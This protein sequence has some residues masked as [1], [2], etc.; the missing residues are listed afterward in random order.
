V[1]TSSNHVRIGKTDYP[2]TRFKLR[3]WLQL[4]DLRIE[5]LDAAK[6][7]DRGR[8][9]LS[10]YSYVSA[11]FSIPITDLEQCHW[12]EITRAYT[13]VNNENAPNLNIPLIKPTDRKFDSSKV[14]W[15]Y[16]G[17]SWFLWANLFANAYGWT[18][19]YIAELDVSDSFSLMQELLVNEQLDKEWQWALSENAF[20]YDAVTKKSKFNPM[21]RP[22]WMQ[23]IAEKNKFS[24]IPNV[25]Y[26]SSEMPVGIVM[27]WDSDQPN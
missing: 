18:L 8:F 5:I 12:S 22:Y 4:E 2:V 25:K 6:Q 14:G 15:D 7:G 26:R 23:T 27:R 20:S 1:E 16:P 11:A 10:L 24:D 13:S 19:E 3:A 9:V 21:K 17:R